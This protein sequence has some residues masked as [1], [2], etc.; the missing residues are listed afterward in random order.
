MVVLKLAILLFFVAVGA[1]WVRPENW[2]PF[3]P[4]GW[5]GITAGAALIF[6]AYIGFDAVSTAAEEAENPQ[7]DMPRAMI[8]SLVVTSII[9]IVV[10]LVMTG[11]VPWNQHGNADPLASAFV[12]RG[13]NWA[14]GIISF[15]AVVSMASVLLVFQLGQPRIFFSM[16]RDGL[17][18]G[19]AARL[20]PRFRTP[21]VTTILTGVFVAFFAAFANINEVIELTN[22]GTLFAFVLVAVGVLALRIR[23]PD[24]HR[25]FRTP[26]VWFVAPAAI[27][28]CGYL[29]IQL[30][31][32]TWTRFV[33]WLVLGI[34]IYALY[35]Y[36]KSRLRSR[37]SE[38]IR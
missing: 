12:D 31:G 7:R 23:E 17:L 4:N 25:P 34:V 22:I 33:L 36:R 30:P 38:A 1:F 15:G 10:T 26:A 21:H 11:L 24:R 14:A 37:Q 13:Y 20:H 3:A 35:G 16:A 9:Y 27:L 32:V 8:G 28:S 19:W 6:F 18:P 2:T 29:M 5:T